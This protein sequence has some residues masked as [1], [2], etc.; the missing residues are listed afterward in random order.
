[1]WMLGASVGPWEAGAAVLPRT[2]K[3]WGETVVICVVFVIF[4][5]ET[6]GDGDGDGDGDGNGNG[7]GDEHG[8]GAAAF[9]EASTSGWGDSIETHLTHDK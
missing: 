8:D 1:M 2:V 5:V 7:N 3:S 4:V 6:A 9:N